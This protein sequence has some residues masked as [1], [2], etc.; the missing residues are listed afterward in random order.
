MRKGLWKLPHCGNRGQS[1]R[2]QESPS[3][4]G[5]PHRFPQCLENS[6]LAPGLGRSFPQFPQPLRLYTYQILKEKL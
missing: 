6:S 5:I 4:Q 2:V 1:I 3:S